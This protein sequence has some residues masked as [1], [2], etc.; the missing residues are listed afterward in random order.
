[1]LTPH[2]DVPSLYTRGPGHIPLPPIVR[3]HAQPRV[4]QLLGR[5]CHLL[6][7]GPVGLGLRNVGAVLL[8]IAAAH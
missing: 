2:A 4:S 8:W 6:A 3:G 5:S 1:M 7:L